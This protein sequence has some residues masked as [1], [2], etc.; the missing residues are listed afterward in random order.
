MNR[1]LIVSTNIEG[2]AGNV[3]WNIAK[4]LKEQYK[5][6]FLT[7]SK[8]RKDFEIDNIHVHEIP[9]RY[10]LF[11]YYSFRGKKYLDEIFDKYDFDLIN[12]HLILPWGFLLRN[13]PVRKIL[14][15]HFVSFFIQ[16]RFYIFDWLERYA[17]KKAIHSADRV[18]SVSKF[19]SLRIS[20]EFNINCCHIPNG[21]DLDRF[22]VNDHNQKNNIVL[23]VGRYIAL[24]GINFLLDAA[25]RL[26]QYE[27]W[28]AGKGPLDGKIKGVNIV[29]HGFVENPEVLM[30]KATICVF[31]SINETSP[32]VGLEAMA[33]G[34]AVI[35]TESGFSEYIEH[36]K[37][38]IIIKAKSTESIVESIRYLMDNPGIR[39]EISNNARKK[40]EQYSWDLICN[41]YANLFD[42]TVCD[43]CTLTQ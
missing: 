25:S 21:I 31:P 26:P 39:R 42:S 20:E 24:K 3:A 12:I 19:V 37:D 43:S 8:I 34:K 14:T 23:F 36:E 18:T 41:K 35:A 1:I 9:F 29:N 6:H 13:Y 28:F 17:F 27:F 33:C 22:S 5:I 11:L 15:D 7:T 2:G 40:A 38:G 4:G 10:P 30:K 32:L 16:R